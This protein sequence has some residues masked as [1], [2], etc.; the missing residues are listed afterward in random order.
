MLG[1]LK[2][3]RAWYGGKIRRIADANEGNVLEQQRPEGNRGLAALTDD[4][5]QRRKRLQPMMGDALSLLGFAASNG[6]QVDAKVRD[7]LLAVADALAAKDPVNLATEQS[8]FTSYE[9]L[10][11]QL[12]P[13]TAETL[14][15]S[16]TILPDW[17]KVFSRAPLDGLNG[18]WGRFFDA[19][20]FVV[21]LGTAC[22]A[23]NYHSLGST[24][25]TRYDGLKDSIS[26]TKSEIGKA[27][28]SVAARQRDSDAIVGSS[29]TTQRSVG[30]LKFDE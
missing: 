20:L 10:T 27:A 14:A 16:Q 23:I 7:A 1:F 30:S 15:A 13:V 8:F 18:T 11:T 4:Q 21:I 29:N 3:F 25:L 6:R 17:S 24:A 2:N 5:E 26:T 28:D 19:L 9:A 22:I 12:R